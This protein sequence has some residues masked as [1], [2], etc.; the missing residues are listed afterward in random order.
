MNR[1]PCLQGGPS[2]S[3]TRFADIKLK[4]PP[5][6]KLLIQLSLQCQQKA[7]LDQMDHP[8]QV[9]ANLSLRVI[10]VTNY[11]IIYTPGLKLHKY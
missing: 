10:N 2:G 5:S 9:E 11:I 4:V 7:V 6:Y 3:G 8:V 1:E